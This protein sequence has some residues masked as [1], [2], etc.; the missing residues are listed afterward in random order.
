[1]P[2]FF[3]SLKEALKDKLLIMV[4][5]LAILSLITG[6]IQNVKTGWI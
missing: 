4:A 1:M 6:M 5:F 3:D 2:P